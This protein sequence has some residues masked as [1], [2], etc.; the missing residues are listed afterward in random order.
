MTT[1]KTFG[2]VVML[3]VMTLFYLIPVI[4]MCV[5]S[6]MP[7]SRVLTDSLTVSRWGENLTLTNYRDVFE[8]V[9]FG[10]FFLNSVVVTGGITIVGLFV[11]SLAGYALARFTFRGRRLFLFFVL[12]MVIVPFEAIAVPL[13]YLVSAVGWRDSYGVLILPFVANAF[14]IFFFYSFFLD[15]PRELEEAAWMDGASTS[16]IYWSVIL[17][18]AKPVFATGAILSFLFNWGAYLWPL[19]VTTGPEFRPLPIAIATFYTLPPL[20]WGDILA[21]GVLMTLPVIV[22]FVLFQRWFVES[23]TTSGLKG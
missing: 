22:A 1:S 4:V 6:L 11:N 2:A 20:Q 14:L 8:R 16:R 9:Q 23:V 3:G 19:L 7:D 13:F 17:P 5:G 10:R 15:I 18:L 12:V 21:F